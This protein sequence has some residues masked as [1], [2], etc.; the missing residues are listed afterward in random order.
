[1]LEQNKTTEF[2]LFFEP[3]SIMHSSDSR[4]SEIV[5]RLKTGHC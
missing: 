3:A 4:R 2:V 5:S 1:M